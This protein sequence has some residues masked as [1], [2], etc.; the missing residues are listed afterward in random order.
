MTVIQKKLL[1]LILISMLHCITAVANN[2]QVDEPTLS[3]SKKA[4][5]DLLEANIENEPTLRYTQTQQ[6]IGLHGGIIAAGYKG[7][8][9]WSYHFLTDLQLKILLGGEWKNKETL[10]WKAI[11]FQPML[12]YTTVSNDT[13]FYLNLLLGPV[14]NYG[15]YTEARTKKDDWKFNIGLTLAGE[16]EFFLTN[17][18]ILLCDGGPIVYF[19]KDDYG[20]FDYYITVGFKINF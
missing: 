13:N 1:S 20:R 6:G 16:I 4:T 14:L 9:E 7:M 19:L 15:K 10:T 5:K 18:L 17:N 2:E 3:K 12:A 8:L 11:V